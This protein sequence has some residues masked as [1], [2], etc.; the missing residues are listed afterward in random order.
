MATSGDTSLTTTRDEIITEALELLGVIEPGVTPN[1]NDITSCARSLNFMIKAWQTDGLAVFTVKRGYLFLERDKHEYTLSSTGDRWVYG[2]TQDVS[3]AAALA[4]Q[5]N[6]TV[7]DD[8]NYTATD[9]IGVAQDD[10]TVLWTTLGSKPGANVLTLDD[11]LTAAS[12]SG[13][14]VMSYSTTDKA[15]E[16]MSVI[17]ASLRNESLNDRPL[18]IMARQE[19]SELSNKTYDGSVTQVYFDDRVTPPVLFTWPESSQDFDVLVL[20]I[21]RVTETFTDAA[22]NPDFPQQWFYP[23]A[24]NLA[25]A[26]GPKFGTPSTNNNFKEVKDQAVFW[27][28]QA[29]NYDAAPEASVTMGVDMGPYT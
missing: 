11:N 16:P 26:V 13:S 6:I 28:N 23:L 15:D 21:K 25:V 24:T 5:A 29:M 20:W 17:E 10:G 12:A 2:Y 9:V 8:T 19:W 14:V 18:D 3:T 4:S 7:A 22:D 1:A 27:Y